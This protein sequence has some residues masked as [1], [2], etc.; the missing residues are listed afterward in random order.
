MNFIIDIL[1]FTFRDNYSFLPKEVAVLAVHKEFTAH[2]IVSAPVPYSTL[3]KVSK[4]S[5]T[6]LCDNHH[7]IDWIEEGISL[8]QLQSNLRRLA[9]VASTFTVYSKEVADYLQDIVGRNIITLEKDPDSPSLCKLHS[10]DNFCIYHGV[11]RSEIYRCALNNAHKI[12]E[13][14]RRKGKSGLDSE[15]KTHSKSIKKSVLPCGNHPQTEDEAEDLYSEV[16]H[17]AE[18]EPEYI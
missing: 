17:P 2:W 6:W 1:G 18:E 8:H 14:V 15:I 9:R 13:F 5:N 7:G 11:E 12:R 3:R 16:Y 4:L 10:N